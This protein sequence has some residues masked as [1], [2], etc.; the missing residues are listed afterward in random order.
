MKQNVIIITLLVL[1]FGVALYEYSYPETIQEWFAGDEELEVETQ[2]LANEEVMASVT[3]A[4]VNPSLLDS[5]LVE[6]R[7]LNKST[8]EIIQEFGEPTRIDLSS[9]G[10]DWWIYS[11]SEETLLQIG[12]DEERVVT[13]FLSGK[14]ID[15]D[16]FIGASYETIN[17]KM[18]LKKDVSVKTNQGSFQFELSDQDL[19]MR[20]LVQDGDGWAQ[21]Y[22]D[23]FTEELTSIRIMSKDIL[24]LQRPYSI[25]YR[26]TL[27]E[28]E[29]LNDEE[30]RRVEIGN[31]QQILELTNVIRKRHKLEAFEWEEPVSNVALGHSKDMHDSNFFSHES[32]T[33]GDVSERFLSGDVA[34]LLA[35]ENIAAKY[36]DG[37]AAVEGWLNS[38][39]HRVNLLHEEFTHLGVGVYRDYYTQ[40]FM[41]PVPLPTH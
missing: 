14:A 41:K 37:L 2:E 33:Y 3:E 5:E 38:E 26:G 4:E 11:I 13:V 19:K 31:E 18:D 17:Q 21:L 29:E 20:P 28:R 30:W 10:Y 9:F 8:N 27:P 15:S 23:S 25:L 39:G 16:S 24:I 12:V 32:P 35:G 34:F 22:F 1:F 7:L 40:N 36:I 6:S